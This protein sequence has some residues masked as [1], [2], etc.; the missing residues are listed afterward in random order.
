MQI[1]A[2]PAE[3]AVRS[4]G[5]GGED[6]RGGGWRGE[7]CGGA[8]WGGGGEEEVGVGGWGGG[9]GEGE[10]EGCWGGGDEG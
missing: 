8:E 1:L 3:P 10:G 7:E 4:H 6:D 5:E 2:R 9:E